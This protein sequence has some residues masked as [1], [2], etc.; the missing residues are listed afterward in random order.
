MYSLYIQTLHS[1]SFVI[2]FGIGTDLQ[3]NTKKPLADVFAKKVFFKILQS[4]GQSTCVG[5]FESKVVG[6]H[7]PA[8]LWKKWLQHRFF[9]VI[10]QNFFKHNFS[11]NLW[12]TAFKGSSYLVFKHKVDWHHCK[13]IKNFH[14][15][16]L[17]K[18]II[19]SKYEYFN[20]ILQEFLI[21]VTQVDNL[22]WFN[23]IEAAVQ[24]CS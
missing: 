14:N 19:G 23:L 18:Q 12:G 1:T 20:G 22:H 8:T 7:Q 21:V 16:F 4:S 9:R 6:L 17:W 3:E 10:L 15:M 24:R 5:V 2:I 13:E 11:E